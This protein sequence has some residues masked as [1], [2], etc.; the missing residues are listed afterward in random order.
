M[1][2]QS[3]SAVIIMANKRI[4]MRSPRRWSQ[5]Q[6]VNT[7]RHLKALKSA[8]KCLLNKSQNILVYCR[9]IF[10]S[11]FASKNVYLDYSTYSWQLCIEI[12]WHWSNWRSFWSFYNRIFSPNLDF[13]KSKI[14]DDFKN[15]LRLRTY[16]PIRAKIMN[17]FVY[18]FGNITFILTKNSTQFFTI[19]A[20]NS[21]IEKLSSSYSDLSKHWFIFWKL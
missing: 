18:I 6:N 19:I 17:D 11:G 8:M 9:K 5:V 4:S 1:L 10:S 14:K 13:P 12:I 2:P 20:F 7:L 15:L 16:N 3:S 21:T